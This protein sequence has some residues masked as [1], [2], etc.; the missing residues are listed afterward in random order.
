MDG[1][2]LSEALTQGGVQ[3]GR[4]VMLA[5]KVF[6]GSSWKAIMRSRASKSTVSSSNLTRF[7]GISAPSVDPEEITPPSPLDLVAQHD[8]NFLSAAFCSLR[9]ASA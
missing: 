7:P 3:V 4:P 5:Q 6:L 1:G 9:L 8:R 2:A